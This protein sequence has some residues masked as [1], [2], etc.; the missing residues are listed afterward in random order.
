MIDM[1]VSDNQIT[2]YVDQ[3]IKI[4]TFAQENDGDFGWA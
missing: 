3:L 1:G 2:G 4:V